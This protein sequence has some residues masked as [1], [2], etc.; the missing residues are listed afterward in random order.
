MAIAGAG[1]R[2]PRLTRAALQAATILGALIPATLA[3]ALLANLG[4]THAAPVYLL[5]VVAIGMRWGTI[6]AVATSVAAFLAYDF[7]FVLPLYTFTINS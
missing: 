3:I 6:P 2:T 7:L 1:G 4:V 5:A